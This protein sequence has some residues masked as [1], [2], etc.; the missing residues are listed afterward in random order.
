MFSVVIPTMWRFPPFI[1]FLADLLEFPLVQEVLLI[2][3]DVDKTPHN[4]PLRHHKL[5]MATPH[6]NMGVNPAWNLGVL[7]S[8]SDNVCIANDDIIFDFKLFQRVLPFIRPEH[9]AICLSPGEAQFQQ[10]PFTNGNI[11]I[12]PWPYNTSQTNSRF[13]FGS[14]FFIHKQSWVPIPE[15]LVIYYGDDWL[16]DTQIANSRMN[17]VINNCM[18]FTPRAAT[19]GQLPGYDQ[20]LHQ[21]GPVYF[22]ELEIYRQRLLTASQLSLDLPEKGTAL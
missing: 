6:H 19:C 3:N 10:E 8:T 7:H 4:A 18:N 12:V 9:G 20:I 21:E 5:R 15:E 14:L 22:R 17:F 13:G 16:L 1:Q 11:D 2:N